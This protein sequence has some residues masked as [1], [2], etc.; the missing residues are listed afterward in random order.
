[1]GL[2]VT[3]R[4]GVEPFVLSSRSVT[5]E[6]DFGGCLLQIETVRQDEPICLVL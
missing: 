2:D 4:D 1:M 3:E 6:A 5:R